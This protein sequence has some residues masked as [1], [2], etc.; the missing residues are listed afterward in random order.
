MKASVLGQEGS[1]TEGR[2][3]EWGDWM[4]KK[5]KKL[6]DEENRKIRVERQ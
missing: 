2:E 1:Y 6:K 4:K 5:K 3:E